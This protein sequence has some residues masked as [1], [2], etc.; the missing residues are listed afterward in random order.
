MKLNPIRT[1]KLKE[2]IVKLEQEEEQLLLEMGKSNIIKDDNEC[3]NYAI[4]MLIDK[5]MYDGESMADFLKGR[6]EMMEG[7]KHEVR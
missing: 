6:N 2:Y 5:H 4:K 7:L 1:V 3:I